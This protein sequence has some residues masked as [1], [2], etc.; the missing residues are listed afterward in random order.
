MLR[1]TLPSQ[2]QV[3]PVPA[4]SRV[5]IIGGGFTGATIARLLALHR[6]YWPHKIVVFEPRAE[7]GGGLAYDADDPSLRLNVAAHRMRAVPGDPQAFL[8]WL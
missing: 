2:K 4:I 8:R 3:P 5:A 7:L 6:Q 1:I